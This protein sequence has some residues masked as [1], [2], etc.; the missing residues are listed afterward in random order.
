[1]INK[2]VF[3]LLLLFFN[4]ISTAQQT[5]DSLDLSKKMII[6]ITPT[7]PFVFSENG[8]YSGLS[9]DSWELLNEELDL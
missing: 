1:M 8:A 2:Y 6:G 4:F 5:S 3:L 7:P 9:V